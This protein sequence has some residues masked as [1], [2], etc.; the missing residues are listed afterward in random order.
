MQSRYDTIVDP[1]ERRFVARAQL[2]AAAVVLALIAAGAALYPVDRPAPQADAVRGAPSA[3]ASSPL[4]MRPIG[5]GEG[6]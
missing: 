5:L 3:P 4:D 2:W 1:A 6:A